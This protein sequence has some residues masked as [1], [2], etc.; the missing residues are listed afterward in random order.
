MSIHLLREIEK[1]KKRVLSLGAIVEEQV[2]KSVEAA[3]KRDEKLAAEVIAED[4]EID[5]ME[6]DIEE[7]CLKV[8]ALYQVVAGDLRFIIAILKMNG[9]LERIGDL[10]VNIAERAQFLANLEPDEM[11]F[12]LRDTAAKTQVMLK[13]S[14][15][16]L[17]NRD[18]ALA[19]RVCAADDEVDAANR[20]A[21]AVLMAAVQKDPARLKTLIHQFTAM[22]Q[23]ERIADHATNIAEDVIYMLQGEIV[24][25]RAEKYSR[26]EPPNQNP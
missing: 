11:L 26:P 18:P 16:A 13:Q 20:Q 15:D 23:L 12:N 21:Y 6:V 14:L 9:D 7:E 4:M 24:R 25:H 5:R 2:R 8:L 1:L 17:V 3:S 19:Y 10:A 22:R